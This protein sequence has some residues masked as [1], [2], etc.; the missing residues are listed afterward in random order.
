[1]ASS[2]RHCEQAHLS[3]H[4]EEAQLT[5]QSMHPEVLDRHVLRPRDDD[6]VVIASAAKQSMTP[7]S[8][9]AASLTLLAM[10]T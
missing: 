8:W 5:W 7:K 9:I 10:T 2:S 4:C 1:M 6:V 3:R